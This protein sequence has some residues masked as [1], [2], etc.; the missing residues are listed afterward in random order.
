MKG[1]LL[2]P[3]AAHDEGHREVGPCFSNHSKSCGIFPVPLTSKLHSSRSSCQTLLAIPIPDSVPR[4][5]KPVEGS[6][7][8]EPHI[9]QLEREERERQ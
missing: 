1:N 5:G 6:G 3:L 7:E 9:L 2:Q 8:A 4:E